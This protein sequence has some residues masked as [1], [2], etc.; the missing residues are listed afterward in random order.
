ML[1]TLRNFLT[2]GEAKLLTEKEFVSVP[3][4]GP[5]PYEDIEVK[6]YIH[7]DQ[8]IR[9][10][11]KEIL[12]TKG[13]LPPKVQ[14]YLREKGG[15]YWKSIPIKDADW[16]N[17]QYLLSRVSEEQVEYFSACLNN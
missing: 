8:Y 7:K 12:T 14:L 3:E 5:M 9:G 16:R 11:E 13:M 15:H 4:L 6:I 17:L 10:L 2:F 1:T